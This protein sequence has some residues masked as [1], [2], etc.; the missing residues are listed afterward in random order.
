MQIADCPEVDLI[1]NVIGI[2]LVIKNGAQVRGLMNIV[3]NEDAR[4]L[5]YYA[6]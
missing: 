5:E 3:M 2:W 6:V 1:R 4:F